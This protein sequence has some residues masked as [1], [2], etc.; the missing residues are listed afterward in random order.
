MSNTRIEKIAGALKREV[1]QIIHAEL[2]DPRIGFVTINRIEL[3]SD[4]RYA[5]VY[6]GIL[7]SKSD[8]EKTLE[9]LT[10]AKGFIKKLIGERLKLRY[11]PEIIFKLDKSAEESIHI[12]EMLENLKQPQK[13]K[14]MRRAKEGEK[15]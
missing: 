2:S 12:S 4:L 3:T 10:S 15:L 1:S 11:V 8:E 5:R 7:G 13:A 6:F 14:K 9:G